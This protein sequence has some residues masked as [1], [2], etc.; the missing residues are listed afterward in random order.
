MATDFQSS[1]G[2]APTCCSMAGLR[3]A[4]MQ[5]ELHWFSTIFT[6]LFLVGGRIRTEPPDGNL[7]IA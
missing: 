5:N 2:R 1:S 4:R 6:D 3:L 7:M